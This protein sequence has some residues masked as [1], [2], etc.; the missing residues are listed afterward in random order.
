MS[1]A[2]A[3]YGF[4]VLPESLPPERRE[5]FA[6]RRANPVGSLVLLR[7]HPELLGLA[8]VNLVNFLAHEVFPNVYVVYT[9]YRFGWSERTIGL[10]LATAGICSALVQAVLT[11]PA[12]SRLGERGAVLTGMTFGILGFA[13][14]GLASAGWVFWLA[15]PLTALWGLGAP[16]VQGIMSRR[17]RASEQGRLQGANGS[18]RGITGMLGP[19]LFTA[20]WVLGRG[21]HIPGAPFFVSSLLL[22]SALAVALR[23]TRR[24]DDTGSA[25]E[26]VAPPTY[27]SEMP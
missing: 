7:S 18:L 20:M 9:I 21:W 24:K 1:L 3:A 27:T 22:V 13:L 4:F 6:W 14:Y 5:A 8:A 23:V 15:V 26:P 11:R 17:V 2:N 25:P 19:G 10:T 16:A 12:V